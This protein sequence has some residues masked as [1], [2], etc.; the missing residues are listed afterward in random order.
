M[1]I[2]VDAS[3]T[4]TRQRTGTEAYAYFL[5]RALIPLAAEHNCQ[6][7]LY[8]N[9]PPQPDLFPQADHVEH[10]IIPFPR[11]WTH[12]RLAWELARRP[13]DVFYTPAHVIPYSLR[14]PSV[15][16]IHDVGF[17]FFPKAHTRS[18]RT[19]L[20]W[21]TQH[22]GRHSRKVIADS[23]ATKDDLI[24]LYKLNPAKIDVIYPGIDPELGPVSDTGQLSSVQNKY[25]VIPPYLL[26]IGTLQ[27]RKNLSRLIQAYTISAVEYQLVLAGKIGWGA[28]P[29]MDEVENAQ[30]NLNQGGNVS[31]KD[32]LHL[33]GYIADQDK[34]ALISGARALLFP[35]LYEGFGFPVVEA[36]VCGTPVLCSNTSSLPE[37]ANGAA[38]EIDPLD[39]E[40]LATGI[41]RITADEDLRRQLV[42]AGIA[43]ARRF[44]WG[45]AAEMV[46]ATLI[47]AGA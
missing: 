45:T 27:P 31:G 25:G 2:G 36:N 46:L 20:S 9:Q 4:V 13:P 41:Q 17:H 38:L 42:S 28:K 10:V 12:G 8:F 39:I 5:I 23:Q 7:K 19:Y 44:S 1:V 15:A 29:L 11:L 35:S 26:Y 32:R 33:P 16:T 21:S 14:I 34:A 43:N 24:R 47:S 30:S 40:G 6:L 18:Q 37:I 3:R 22:N